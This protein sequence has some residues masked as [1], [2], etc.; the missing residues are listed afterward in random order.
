MKFSLYKNIVVNSLEFDY[1]FIWKYCDNGFLIKVQVW[2]FIIRMKALIFLK[3]YNL[4]NDIAG[5]N[6]E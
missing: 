5:I 3:R 2:M 6:Y 4:L 1:F